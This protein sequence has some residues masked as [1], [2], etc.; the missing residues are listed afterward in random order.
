VLVREEYEELLKTGW[1]E[2]KRQTRRFL[3]FL[4]TVLVSLG[5]GTSFRT[6]T[7]YKVA[8]RVYANPR[9]LESPR[10]IEM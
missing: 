10:R 4:M 6:L 1:R 7:A 3:A 2:S 8:C 9:Q 5:R